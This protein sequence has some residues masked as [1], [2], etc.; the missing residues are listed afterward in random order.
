MTADPEQARQWLARAT[1]DLRAAQHGLAAEPPLAEDVCFHAQQAAEKVLKAYLTWKGI[2]F[3]RT[4][5][6][7]Y[8]IDMGA[9]ADAELGAL[10]GEAD[11]L[12]LYAV[13]FRYPHP[14]SA[15][16][17]DEAREA[18]QIPRRV[19]DFVLERMPDAMRQTD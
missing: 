16:T 12:T 14:G 10:H 17:T 1:E 18:M 11:A 13:R 6:I 15:P 3:E 4:H 8:L 19:C 5:R 7:A 9:R 2:E